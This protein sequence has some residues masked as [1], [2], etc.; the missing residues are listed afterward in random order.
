MTRM[1]NHQSGVT[2]QYLRGIN[3]NK[4][5]IRIYSGL[6]LHV[7]TGLWVST[8]SYQD[9]TAAA[10][11]SGN[12]FMQ[13]PDNGMPVTATLFASIPSTSALQIQSDTP[14]P[15]PTTQSRVSKALRKLTP[16]AQA[17]VNLEP[18][19]AWVTQICA[20]FRLL[21]T[22]PVNKST[23]VFYIVG[24][25][26]SP[27]GLI[28]SSTSSE[29]G[30]PPRVHQSSKRST[31]PSPTKSAASTAWSATQSVGRK[32]PATRTRFPV[33]SSGASLP[34]VSKHELFLLFIL[35]NRLVTLLIVSYF[36]TPNLAFISFDFNT[37]VTQGWCLISPKYSSMLLYLFLTITSVQGCNSQTFIVHF[38]ECLLICHLTIHKSH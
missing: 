31:T 3:L 37:V 2:I 21:L 16:E 26:P 22:A 20:G 13:Q 35:S 4:P 19:F 24:V 9:C 1:I 25:P 15:G 34:S 38:H 18:R 8:G 28:A 32:G 33:N 11:T 36:A 30:S 17:T 6:R 5:K 7:L 29:A 14:P 12:D 27:A 10:S 23:S